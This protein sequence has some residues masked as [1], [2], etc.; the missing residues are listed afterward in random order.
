MNNLQ[1]LPK[2]PKRKRQPT[3]ACMREQLALAADEII[4]GRTQYQSGSPSQDDVDE[5]CAILRGERDQ[6][7]VPKS[8]WRRLMDEIAETPIA[9]LPAWAR[10]IRAFQRKSDQQAA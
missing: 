9:E 7:I 8:F 6:E 5:A 1:L 3:A 10:V 2:A 4:A